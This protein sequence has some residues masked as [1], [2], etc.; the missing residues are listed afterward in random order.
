MN[1][2]RRQYRGRSGTTRLLRSKRS[3]RDSVW[4]VKNVSALGR[5]SGGNVGGHSHSPWT[6]G[7][8]VNARRQKKVKRVCNLEINIDHTLYNAFLADCNLDHTKTQESLV[9]LLTSHVTAASDM[10]RNTDFLGIAD[11]AF[12]VQRVIINNSKSCDENV[13]DSN[14]F[15]ASNLDSTH[16]LHE[17]S[18]INH[19]DFCLSYLWTYRD[20]VG[21]TLGLAYK[22]EPSGFPGN[23]GGVCEKYQGGSSLQSSSYV[24]K[25]SLNTGIVTFLNQNVRVP[26]RVTHITFTH[27]LGHNFGS[28]HDFPDECVPGSSLGNYIMY[29]SATHGTLP[30][31]RKF[32][33]CS[34]RNISMVLHQLLSGEGP[35]ANC[36]QEPRGPF[37]GNFIREEG[38]ECDC[39]FT[40]TECKESCCYPREHEEINRRSCTFKP[41]AVCSPTNQACC[42]KNCSVYKQALVCREDDDCWFEARCDGL[43]ADCPPSEP[44]PN[45]TLCNH[46]TQ[47]CDG[48]QCKRSIC[49]KFSLE[50]CFLTGSFRTPDEMCL[51]ACREPGPRGE[52]KE[53]CE[54]ELMRDLC[55]R[56]MEPGAACNDLH[57]YCD[58]FQ[59]CRPIDTQGPLTRLHQIIFGRAGLS[60]AL[61]KYWYVTVALIGLF[62]FLMLSLIRV[63]AVHT[64]SSNPNLIRNKKIG[65]SLRN[66]VSIIKDVVLLSPQSPICK[67]RTD[68]HR[69]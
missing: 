23:T 13:R 12:E 27:E 41:A 26:E 20:F 38:E 7:R 43:T 9:A 53:A 67:T 17:L 3:V 62:G 48:G 66:P 69:V 5:M 55:G 24:G 64:P 42:S 47:M 25:L 1:D 15:C 19:N 36:L 31:N 34:V 28:P 60:N 30:N 57:G 45:G 11:I 33:P 14:P 35:R 39:G 49:T 2:I 56:R 29:E 44:K 21:G 52:C 61:V 50:E 22:A 63:C 4:S 18:K 16:V 59:K 58:V 8:P 54:F 37:C 10:F 68:V 40:P 32:S 51:I 6:T 46:G 65:E